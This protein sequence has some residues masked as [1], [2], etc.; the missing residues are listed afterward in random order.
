MKKRRDP[1][2][3]VALARG[4]EILRAF[5]PEEVQLGNI[6]IA[7]RTGIPKGTVSRLTYT[8]TA[9][10]YLR[11]SEL[12]GMFSI[13]PGILALG[14]PVLVNNAI[15][16]VARPLMEKLAVQTDSA[17]GFGVRDGSYVIHLEYAKG[18]TAAIRDIAAGFRVS[19][20]GSA[21]GWACL[22]GMRPE[23]RAT[24]LRQIKAE[25]DA[26]QFRD[27]EA[28]LGNA[29]KHVWSEGFCISFGDVDPAF[30]AVAAP[31]MHEGRRESYVVNCIGP[32]YLFKRERMVKEVGPRLL[33]LT[34]E[35]RRRSAPLYS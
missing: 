11:Y 15:H 21:T 3:N 31:F 8:L 20:A 9:F 12:T 13:G 24:A 6:E 35:L 16:L 29:M 7:K 26:K 28:K 4:L 10:G 32:G 2:I 34:E 22:A 33:R 19:L 14:Y 27:F 30:N 17:V 1:R 25:L 5:R 18:T 23:E